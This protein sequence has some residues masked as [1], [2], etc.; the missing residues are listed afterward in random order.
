MS[1]RGIDVVSAPALAL[2]MLSIA[3]VF[4]VTKSASR[5]LSISFILVH[6]FAF[7]DVIHARDGDLSEAGCV[8]MLA[9]EGD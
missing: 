2:A 6:A 1:V 7:F 9:L 3:V 5:L 4:A 8:V